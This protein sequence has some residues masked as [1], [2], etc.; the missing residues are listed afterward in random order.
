MLPL[1]TLYP[2][3]PSEASNLAPESPSSE[4]GVEKTYDPTPLPSLA[5][6]VWEMFGQAITPPELTVS[7]SSPSKSEFQTSQKPT[8]NV[9]SP[10]GI[11]SIFHS[12]QK[13]LISPHSDVQTQNSSEEIFDLA[14]KASIARQISL[15]RI[16]HQLLIPRKTKVENATAREDANIDVDGEKLLISERKPTTA[17]LVNV[18]AAKIIKSERAVFER[19]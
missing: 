4:I 5:D 8:A 6:P 14:T 9:S 17:T 19:A 2:S 7:A 10:V 11:Q 12:P 16:Q 1:A 13:S 18:M 15:S 3:W